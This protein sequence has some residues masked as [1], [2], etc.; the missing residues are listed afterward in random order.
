M[1]LSLVTA[2]VI[3]PVTLT[4]A[5]L[6]CRQDIDDENALIQTLIRAAREHVEA[7]CHR[8]LTTQTWDW[9]LDGF[10]CG[11][12]HLP[13]G[14]VTTITS[15][16][17]VDGNGDSQTWS[18]ALYQTD[19]PVGPKSLR[20]RIQPAYQQFYPS[21][22]DQMN[23]VTVRFVAGYGN[24]QQAIPDGIRHAMLQLIGHWFMNR[25]VVAIGVGIGAVEIPRTVDAQLYPFISW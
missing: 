21:T 19:L 20:G 18:S 5:K 2:P 9:K 16:T 8:A 4:E 6:Q 23:A 22:R 3:E 15:I 17:Y 13:M 12:L 7:Y 11:A 14:N 25:E 10:P 24:T 1:A